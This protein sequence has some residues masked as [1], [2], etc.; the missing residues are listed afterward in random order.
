MVNSDYFFFCIIA[1]LGRLTAMV[2]FWFFFQSFVFFSVWFFFF[3]VVVLV[4]LLVCCLW[5][6]FFFFLKKKKKLANRS[7]WGRCSCG[8]GMRRRAFLNGWFPHR[9]CGVRT[10]SAA[11]PH[12]HLGCDCGNMLCHLGIRA[13]GL[14]RSLLTQQRF[15]LCYSRDSSQIIFP[16]PA[17]PGESCSAP[18]RTVWFFWHNS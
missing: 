17:G 15:A 8:R 16:L 14:W 7:S 3:L 2:W 6:F 13:A 11:A 9:W 10:L 12:R 5:F 4:W 18:W 1:G